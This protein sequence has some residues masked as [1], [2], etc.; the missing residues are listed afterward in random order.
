MPHCDLYFHTP[1]VIKIMTGLS[2]FS[3]VLV[4]I[5]LVSGKAT[6]CDEARLA[7]LAIQDTLVA[8]FM[9]TALMQAMACTTDESEAA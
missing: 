4:S 2:L 3:F 5:A 9:R 6:A 1:S 8:T 7:T